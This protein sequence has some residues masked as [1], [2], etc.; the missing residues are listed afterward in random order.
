LFAAHS[1]A[2]PQNHADAFTLTGRVTDSSGD[3]LSQARISLVTNGHEI[4]A[5]ISDRDGRFELRGLVS[6]TYELAVN[7]HGF[8][9]H[10]QKVNV[11][12][13][14][15]LDL[16]LQPSSVTDSMTVTPARTAQ[17]LGDLPA[18]ITILDSRDASQAAAQTVDDL[19]RQVP[20]FSIFRR[21]S[22]LV[23]NPTTQGVSLRGAGASGS[24]RT[25]VLSDGL[26]LNDAFGGWVYWDRIPRAAIDRIEVVRGGSSDLYGSDALSGVI[27]VISKSMSQSA[28]TLETSYGNHNTADVSFFGG[29]KAG[30]WGFA[31]GGEALH[32]DGY[33]IV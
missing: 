18:S 24:S 22:S 26:P 27:N 17:R 33:F 13:T 3:A 2:A 5:A 25:L 29:V 4:A 20:G 19:L 6:G 23:A 16:T 31:V 1:Q 8:G 14:A 7:A 32:T 9:T 10:R 28:F 21:S 30:A 15:S 11:P 12:A